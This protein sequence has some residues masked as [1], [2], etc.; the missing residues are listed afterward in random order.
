MAK[1]RTGAARSRQRSPIPGM[2]GARIRAIRK[3]RGWTIEQ[4]AA[5]CRLHPKQLGFIERGEHGFRAEGQSLE[6]VRAAP[7]AAV[8]KN[9]RPAADR[10]DH[11]RQHLDASGHAVEPAPAVIRDD[12]AV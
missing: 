12:D 8:E 1:R 10:F 2:L 5:V 7:H 6:N 3:N 4:A 11:F 9:F